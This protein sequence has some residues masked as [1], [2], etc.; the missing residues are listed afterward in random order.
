MPNVSVFI[1]PELEPIKKDLTR[2]WSAMVYKL[3]KNAHKGKWEGTNIEKAFSDME[4][5]A[6]ELSQ[7]IQENSFAEILLEGAD[8]ANFAMIITSVALNEL[9]R[10]ES[11][12]AVDAV[13]SVLA[14]PVPRAF[15][16]HSDP[17]KALNREA[18]LTVQTRPINM[19][20]PQPKGGG[21]L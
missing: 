8:V 16:P 14:K 9:P 10:D 21:K 15:D 13:V 5:E 20:Y 7:A 2:F 12:T 3:R 19:G 17:T 18:T 1:P 11:K 6:K 4:F